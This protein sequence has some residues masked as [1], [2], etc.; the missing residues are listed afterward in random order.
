MTLV[1]TFSD[2][3]TADTHPVKTWQIFKDASVVFSNSGSDSISFVPTEKGIYTATFS[4][5]DDD[6]GGA[7]I[8]RLFT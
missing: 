4:V 2:L 5:T 7:T 3:G 6:G 8:R 1:G